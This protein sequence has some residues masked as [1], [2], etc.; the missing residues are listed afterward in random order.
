VIAPLS[1]LEAVR[2]GR[3]A[4]AMPANVATD[5]MWPGSLG[6]Q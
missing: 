6:R 2:L 4:P 5:Q 1:K 3:F